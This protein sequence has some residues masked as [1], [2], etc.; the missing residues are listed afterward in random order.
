MADKTKE[1]EQNPFES[2][3]DDE[4]IAGEFEDISKA[5]TTQVRDKVANKIANVKGRIR[6]LKTNLA[7]AKFV[8][9]RDKIAFFFGQNWLVFTFFCVGAVPC[10]FHLFYAFFFVLLVAIRFVIYRTKRQHYFLL[11]FCYWANVWTILYTFVY[12]DNKKIF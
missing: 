2:E 3:S 11:E 6:K 5:I 9:L 8:R 4:D 10:Y 12:S 1:N 7:T